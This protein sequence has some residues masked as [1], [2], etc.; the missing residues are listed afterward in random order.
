MRTFKQVSDN[1]LNSECLHKLK[2]LTVHLEKFQALFD[3][4]FDGLVDLSNSPM[5]TD[6]LNQYIPFHQGYEAPL[7]SLESMDAQ[8]PD[9]D[10]LMAFVA[11]GGNMHSFL[12]WTR[13]V[14]TKG[15]IRHLLQSSPQAFIIKSGLKPGRATNEIYLTFVRQVLGLFPSDVATVIERAS[16]SDRECMFLNLVNL[17][18]A[19]GI[20]ISDIIRVKNVPSDQSVRHLT[21]TSNDGLMSSLY[22]CELRAHCS[23]ESGTDV[24]SNFINATFMSE[25][26]RLTAMSG[27]ISCVH[28]RI[29]SR[30]MAWGILLGCPSRKLSEFSAQLTASAL[31][32]FPEQ[33]TSMNFDT[34]NMIGLSVNNDLIGLVKVV[35]DGPLAM[36]I[37]PDY[38][39]NQTLNCLEYLHDFDN[40]LNINDIFDDSGF[41]HSNAIKILA[42][43]GGHCPGAEFAI[44]DTVIEPENVLGI[45]SV[46]SATDSYG[47]YTADA[48]VKLMSYYVERLPMT[49][50]TGVASPLSFLELTTDMKDRSRLEFK[51]AYEKHPEFKASFIKKV[52][53]MEGLSLEH[54]HMFSLSGTDIPKTMSRTS[55]KDRGNLLEDELGI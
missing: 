22:L 53:Q 25:V 49:C 9:Y 30:A 48:L 31:S 16:Q 13:P 32:V 7:S 50:E 35:A 1:Y 55:R 12:A 44:I 42:V 5:F 8:F 15:L 24:L 3:C 14:D 36:M 43:I 29:K 17:S 41:R 4:K 28:H 21:G 40:N 34:N 54:L 52:E 10:L 33:Y 23:I 26:F 46:L 20:D 45:L 47:K 37:K 38:D 19:A 6:Y 39:M 27:E 18:L 2:T 11:D 51:R